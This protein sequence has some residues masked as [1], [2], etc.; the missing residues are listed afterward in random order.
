[1]NTPLAWYEKSSRFCFVALQLVHKGAYAD[2]AL[3]R[4]LR[5]ADLT[6]PDRRLVTELV[7][8]VSEGS[9][10]SML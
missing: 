1:M 10:R 4:V 5:Q 3:D 9:E 2:A 6:A 8:G 7:Y